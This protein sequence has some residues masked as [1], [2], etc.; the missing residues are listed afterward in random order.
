MLLVRDAAGEGPNPAR[1][2]SVLTAMVC[3][4]A[5][6]LKLMKALGSTPPPVLEKLLKLG[7]TPLL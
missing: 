4:L 5:L 2:V 7:S 6:V 3:V 1:S